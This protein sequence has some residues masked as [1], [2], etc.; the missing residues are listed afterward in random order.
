MIPFSLKVIPFNLKVFLCAALL[1]LVVERETSYPSW[2]IAFE[3]IFRSTQWI[4]SFSVEKT[5][6]QNKEAT[7]SISTYIEAQIP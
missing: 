1:L 3:S 5:K 7:S 2:T 6:D 4:F